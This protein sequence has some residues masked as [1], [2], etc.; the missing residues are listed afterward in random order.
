MNYYRLSQV[1]TQQWRLREA[2]AQLDKAIRLAPDN[3]RFHRA[4]A[5][6]L[7]YQHNLNEA[8]AEQQRAVDLSSDKPFELTELAALNELAGNDSAAA[9]NLKQA[10][11]LSPASQAAHNAAHQ[12]LVVLLSKGKRWNDLIEEFNRSIQIQPT[13]AALHL[14]LADALL[15]ADKPDEALKELKTATDLDTNDPRPYE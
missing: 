4:R 8:I 12:K 15:K 14:G 13:V 10:I 7:R 3:A 5:S 2:D 1:Y 9:D 6:I 11:P